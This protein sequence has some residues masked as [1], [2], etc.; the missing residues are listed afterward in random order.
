MEQQEQVNDTKLAVVTQEYDAHRSSQWHAH[1]S[2]RLMHFK[3]AANYAAKIIEDS[4]NYTFDA[5]ANPRW[6]NAFSA[7]LGH[8][9][10]YDETG[11]EVATFSWD[12]SVY[13]DAV[14][15]IP[16]LYAAT[17]YVLTAMNE[18]R[19]RVRAIGQ[20]DMTPA[21][22]EKEFGLSRGTVRKYIFDHREALIE[23]GVVRR[24]DA[25]TLLCKRGWAIHRWG[26]KS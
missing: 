21:E 24:A 22:I 19:A 25:R 11:T 3:T 12:R 2:A 6:S 10:V 14:R 18:A 16:Q 7:N 23:T 15:G 17:M 4:A 1:L 8:L 5:W 20:Q 13:Y 9:G 26:N